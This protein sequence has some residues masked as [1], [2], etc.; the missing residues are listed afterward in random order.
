MHGARKKDARYPGRMAL[1]LPA[2]DACFTVF[3]QRL[4]ARIDVT[5]WTRYAERFV[6]ARVGLTEDRRYEM[7]APREDAVEVV[8]APPADPR[9]PSFASGTRGCWGRPRTDGDIRAAR[10]APETGAGLADLAQRCPQVW[11][12]ATLGDDD[13]IALR[14]AAILA[15]VMLGPILSPAGRALFGPKTA[16]AR[17]GL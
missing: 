6:A 3:S 7:E 13:A 4:D 2:Q 8:V 10:E 14:L 9:A 16:R 15:G 11:L 1:V 12:I 17:L 5:E